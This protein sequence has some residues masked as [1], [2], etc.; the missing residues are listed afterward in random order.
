MPVKKIEM[1][2]KSWATSII[3]S[4]LVISIKQKT[5]IPLQ[6]T[7]KLTNIRLSKKSIAKTSLASIIAAP[8]TAF[9][10]GLG[11]SQAALIGK[12]FLKIEDPREFLF[13]LGAINTIK[14]R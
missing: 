3:L 1:T 9:L 13:L 2:K 7:T 5:K 14:I 8:F 10:P 4:N 6:K 12:Q 11:A